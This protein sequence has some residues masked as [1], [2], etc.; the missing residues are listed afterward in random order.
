MAKKREITIGK[1]NV[2]D[3]GCE[4]KAK[5][6]F[7]LKMFEGDTAQEHVANF[8]L[9]MTKERLVALA[10]NTI[11]IDLQ[12]HCRTLETHAK[13]RDLTRSVLGMK[14][15]YPGRGVVVSKRDL[16]PEEIAAKAKA[17]PKYRAE[18]MAQL[19]AMQDELDGNGE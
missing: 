1:F 18:L 13:V 5:A 2:T 19:A 9:S 11:V 15:V 12:K 17:D 3:A 10:M 6:T 14:D 4:L 7:S 16:T 8:D